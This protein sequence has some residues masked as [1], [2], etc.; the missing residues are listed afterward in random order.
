MGKIWVIWFLRLHACAVYPSNLPPCTQFTLA[1]GYRMR[2]VR[3]QLATACPLYANNLLPSA[4]CM[5]AN[6]HAQT[7]LAIAYMRSV[8]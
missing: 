2:S 5:L 6:F 1:I 3:W 7:T 4:Q 8:H